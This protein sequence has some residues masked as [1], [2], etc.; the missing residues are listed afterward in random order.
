MRIEKMKLTIPAV[1]I[2]S[3][4][5]LAGCHTGSSGLL[6]GRVVDGFGNPLGG[7][8]VTITLSGKEALHS[9]DRWGNFQLY[10]PVGDYVMRIAFTNPDAGLDFT[11]E[12]N[13]RIITGE[14][15]LGTFTLL[16]VQNFDAWESYRQEDYASAI[17]LFNEQAELARSGQIVN[18]PWM[19][20]SEGEPNENTL[21]TQGVLSAKN[22]L[23]WCYARGL[24]DT[25]QGKQNFTESLSGGYNNYDAMVGLAAIAVS[26]GDGQRA[27]DLIT[28]VIDEPGYYDT[29]QIHDS[30]SEVDLMMLKSLAE[31]MLFD[32]SDSIDTAESVRNT[33]ATQG[34]SGSKNLLEVLDSLR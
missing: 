10:A 29:S 8:A 28:Q 20:Y 11:M 12:E 1:L 3:L 5:L 14:Q 19:R 22:G 13:V 30:I 6:S 32:D 16:S 25:A 2:I 18:L 33:V 17:S 7:D 31:F 26:E 27:L 4:F 9:P 34:N 24:G 21:L 15:K 23:G